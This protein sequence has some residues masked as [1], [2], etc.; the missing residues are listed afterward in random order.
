MKIGVV[1]VLWNALSL[2]EMLEKAQA[3]GLDAVELGAG[4]LAGTAHVDPR[5]VLA[6]PGYAEAIREALDHWGL[7]LSALSVHGNPV[8]PVP[9]IARAHDEAFR[10]ACEAAPKLGVATVN[11]FSGCP[12]DRDGGMT[13]NWVT[14]PW[15]PEF[16]ALHDWQWSDVVIPYWEGAA[17]FADD[18]GVR[19][20]FEMHPGMVV[21]NPETLLRL[22]DAVGPAIGANFDPSHLVWQGIDVIGAIRELAAH[23][24][25]YH[26]H[27]KDTYVDAINIRRNGNIDPKP[28]TQVADRAWTF[29]TVGYGQGESFWRQFVSELRVGGFDGVLSI[30][31]EDLLASVD[32]GLSR[33]VD[34]LRRCIL[35]DA[36]TEAWWT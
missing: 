11:C 18:H 34:M 33:A 29:R 10:V 21:Y 4:N 35:V 30:E 2:D 16:G 24:A 36:P 15:P 9:E 32:E 31:H 25:I 1:A 8:H 13:P 19:L 17:R 6:E 5:R 12:G 7:E 22:R 3:Q 28:Y 26:V 23:D 20:G 14:C 27:A